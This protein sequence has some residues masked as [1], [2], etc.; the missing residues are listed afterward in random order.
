MRL[1]S[2]L[3]LPFSWEHQERG[4]FGMILEKGGDLSPSPAFGEYSE[5]V[6]VELIYPSTLHRDCFI[7]CPMASCR[8]WKRKAWSNHDAAADLLD[9]QAMFDF[10][11]ALLRGSDG[12]TWAKQPCKEA[13][14]GNGFPVLLPVLQGGGT[15]PSLFPPSQRPPGTP[16]YWAA[17]LP[18]EVRGAPHCLRWRAGEN[19]KRCLL[20]NAE[21]L[22]V[23]GKKPFETR[24][25]CTGNMQENI[26]SVNWTKMQR[27][28]KKAVL[29]GKKSLTFVSECQ[30]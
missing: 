12:P 6:W 30:K 7:A 20:G 15:S 26:H 11:F 14:Q 3:F 19:P 1:R 25:W 27:E 18:S 21:F 5:R 9:Q 13:W 4:G 16:K 23:S 24:A 8:A 29:N 10:T 17:L 22:K 28:K 2:G